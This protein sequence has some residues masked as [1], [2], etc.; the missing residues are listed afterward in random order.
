[1]RWVK[2]IPQ[3]P[4]HQILIRSVEECGEKEK[5]MSSNHN[6]TSNGPLIVNDVQLDRRSKSPSKSKPRKSQ[7]AIDSPSHSEENRKEGKGNAPL[8]AKDLKLGTK[9]NA[10]VYQ[11]CEPG[12]VLDLDGIRGMYHFKEND[13]KDFKIG[14]EMRVVCSSFSSKGIPVMSDVD[15]N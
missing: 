5:S 13:K 10:K 8:S 2:R 3:P 14:D 9:V 12:L 4:K 15:D 1:M 11:I 6:Q 7:D